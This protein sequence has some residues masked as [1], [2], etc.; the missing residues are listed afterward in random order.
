MFPITEV[1][2]AARV[3]GGIEEGMMPS[4]EQIKPFMNGRSKGSELFNDLFY[5]GVDGLALV[6]R[7]GVDAE[8]A[9]RH[10]QTIMGSFAPKHEIKTASVAFLFNEWFDMEH[11]TWT[12]KGIKKEFLKK[13]V[14]FG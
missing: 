11:S 12:K 4:P 7:D 13:E 14:I 9:W 5:S 8:K 6:P 2:D 10:I 1:D 3:F